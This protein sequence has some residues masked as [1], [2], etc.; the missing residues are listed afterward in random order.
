MNARLRTAL[1]TRRTLNRRLRCT[2]RS[3]H[4]EGFKYAVQNSSNA[5][6]YADEMDRGGTECVWNGVDGTTGFGCGDDA[7][8]EALPSTRRIPRRSLCQPFSICVCDGVFESRYVGERETKI[9]MECES[10]RTADIVDVC[11]AGCDGKRKSERVEECDDEEHCDGEA[12]SQRLCDDER[13]RSIFLPTHPIRP[14]FLSLLP[15]CRDV[16][17]GE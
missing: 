10:I 1:S 8:V 14:S 3:V 4:V 12:I 7:Q 2:L 6:V 5:Y 16:S 13:H 11:Y 15:S 9:R 17:L